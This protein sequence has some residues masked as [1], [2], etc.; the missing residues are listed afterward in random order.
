MR[1]EV[2]KKVTIQILQVSLRN[3]NEK[4]RL[5]PKMKTQ[6]RLQQKIPYIRKIFFKYS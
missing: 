2:E 3:V 1:T 4:D 6:S 5:Q